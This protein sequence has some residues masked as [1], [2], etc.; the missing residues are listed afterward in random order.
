MPTADGRGEAAGEDANV[1]VRKTGADEGRGIRHR[2]QRHR[3]LAEC[4]ELRG[5]RVDDG[6]YICARLVDFTVDEALR[7]P[8]RLAA[9][10]PAVEVAFIDIRRCD[11]AGRDIPRDEVA[12]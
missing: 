5:V 1:I 10:R 12:V 8:R 9:D 2:A 3:A 4:D 7:V 6:I 11:D